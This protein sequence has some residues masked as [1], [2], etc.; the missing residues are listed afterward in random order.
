[1]LRLDVRI[2]GVLPLVDRALGERHEYEVS[3][4]HRVRDFERSST[5]VVDRHI[6]Q[7]R[8]R[9]PVPVDV[10]SLDDRSHVRSPLS[11]VPRRHFAHDAGV[12]AAADYLLENLQ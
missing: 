6:G 10:A 12:D 7:N 2:A 8:Q 5:R 1:M 11:R 4:R 9:E 3:R